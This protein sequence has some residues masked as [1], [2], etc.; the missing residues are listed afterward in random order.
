MLT[1]QFLKKENMNPAREFIFLQCYKAGLYIINHIFAVWFC[2][3]KLARN[4]REVLELFFLCRPSDGLILEI[5]WKNRINPC[6]FF[7]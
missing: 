6:D 2:D 3:P 4:E 7:G 5:L 1:C